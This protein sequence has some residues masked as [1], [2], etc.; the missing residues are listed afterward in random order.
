MISFE[1]SE[2]NL[3]VGNIFG[4]REA[5]VA[6]LLHGGGQTRH[7]WARPAR[8]LAESGW[9]TI[10]IDLRGHG[11]SEWVKSGNYSFADFASD[12]AA[13]ARQIA[14]QFG[15]KPV[16]IGASLGGIS[17]LLAEGEA[18]HPL[19]AALVMVDITPSVEREG[20]NHIRGFMS[21]RLEEGFASI[22]EAADAVAAYLPNRK[23]P[24][25]AEGLKKNLRLHE[26]GRYRWHWD[27][28]F[29]NGERPIDN[30][31]DEVA[32]RF[33]AAAR[34]IDIPT[35]LVRGR[36]SELVKDTHVREFL[37]LVPHARYTDISEA[38]HMVAGDRNDIFASAVAE[39]LD[40]FRHD[41]EALMAAKG[42]RSEL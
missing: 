13:V 21:Q 5:P 10:A 3:L 12:N 32:P 17:A 27:P 24:P 35:L 16:V 14:A 11:Q 29:I 36:Q 4:D 38:G 19:F 26:D 37:E 40:H 22:E 20:V 8:E 25:S 7:A 41:P 1:G 6:L 2:G 42:R 15:Q 34:G 39:F 30:G 28:R 33:A 18:D 23:R 31:R 9:C